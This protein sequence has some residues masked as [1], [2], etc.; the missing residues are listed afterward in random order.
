MS[1]AKGRKIW[2]VKERTLQYPFMLGKYERPMGSYTLI[3]R[4]DKFDTT[5]ALSP[6]PDGL[7]NI[8]SAA[9]AE[10]IFNAYP[11]LGYTERNVLVP[12][13]VANLIGGAMG[14]K[15]NAEI[16]VSIIDDIEQGNI[17]KGMNYN[18]LAAY[19]YPKW[20]TEVLLRFNGVAA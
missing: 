2:Y 6:Y 16:I 17:T 11:H 19:G 15:R 8:T 1:V 9:A 13:K 14:I 7:M 18:K 3:E 12:M 10:S 20:L 5:T 4:S